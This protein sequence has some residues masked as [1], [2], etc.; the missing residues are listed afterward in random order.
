[1]A[2]V[3]FVQSDFAKYNALQPKDQDT[4]YF[5][6]DSHR[7]Y[8][9]DKLFSG[10]V[11]TTVSTFPEA[12]EVNT[13]YVNTT[14]GSVK[15]W[16]GNAYQEVVKPNVN[17]ISGAGDGLHLPTTKAVVDY[18]TEAIKKVD[19]TSVTNRL[20]AID[21]KFIV[22]EGEGEG[23]I[24][25]A[26]ADAKAY[27]DA[28]GNG[29]VNTNKVA[30]ESLKSSKVDKAASLAGY[31]IKDAYTKTEVNSEI[32]KEIGKA[33]HL[34]RE[35]VEALPG[36]ETANDHTI[37]M[38][39]KA[40]GT[41]QQQYDEY[42]LVVSGDVKSFEKIGDS[43]VDLTNYALKTEVETAKQDA[44]KTAGTN[45]DQKIAAEIQKL[46][47]ADTAVENQYVS[48]VIETDGKIA[49]TRAE[50]P[51]KSV[52]EGTANGAIAVN[53][54]DVQVHGLGSAAYVGTET[55]ATAAQGEKVEQLFQAM[56]WTEL[57]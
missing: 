1:M 46:D 43:T 38:V 17:A 15:Y 7:I 44:I 40:S 3:K 37:Y 49:V 28:L 34:K 35:I 6:T 18:V 31:G 50:L 47:V 55:F 10:G 9:G 4:L 32:Q 12:G 53:G 26:L 48:Q 45:A 42:M 21:G 56:T 25:K 29:Q 23:S 22:I 20:D 33:A 16:N 13:L 54:S 36:V 14:D 19:L 11:F 41:D 57:Q 39:K 30:I 2:L 8:K 51:V 52:A 5:I 27:T 24:K